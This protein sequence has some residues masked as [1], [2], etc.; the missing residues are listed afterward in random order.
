ML[1]LEDMVERGEIHLNDPVEKYLPESVKVP[2]HIRKKITLLNLATHTSGL[3]R[4][5][6]NLTPTHGLPENAFADYSVE[7]MYLFLDS[8]V[9]TR[10]RGNGLNIPT[11]DWRCWD[12]SWRAKLA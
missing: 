12:M 7:R 2:A 3:P 9:L 1:A 11:L 6:D 4:D 5:P 8:Y 10:D